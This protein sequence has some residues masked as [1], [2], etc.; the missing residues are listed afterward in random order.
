[1]NAHNRRDFLKK[2]ALTGASAFTGHTLLNANNIN[3]NLELLSEEKNIQIRN[4]LIVPK[5]NG[6]P[7]TGTFLDEISHDI[8]HQNWGEKE[9]DQD[10]QHMK[11]IGIDTVIMIRSGYRKFITYPSQYLIKKGCFMP[12]TD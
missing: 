2:M 1:M 12:S 8:P 5:N 9:W 3:S 7:I 4:E 6:L 10:F 11:R